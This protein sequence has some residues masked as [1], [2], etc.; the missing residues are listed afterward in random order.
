MASDIIKG[1]EPDIFKDSEYTEEEFQFKVD[2]DELD[3]GDAGVLLGAEGGY[4][5]SG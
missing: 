2:E 4:N 3:A 1:I 5:E